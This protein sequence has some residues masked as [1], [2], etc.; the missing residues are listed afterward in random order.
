MLNT[1]TNGCSHPVRHTVVPSPSHCERILIAGAG[2]GFDL[3]SGLPI[4]FALHEH[5]ETIFLSN[6]T[7]TPIT[8]TDAR[9]VAAGVFE[10]DA[11]TDCPISY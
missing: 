3:L 1:S 9:P 8:R 4:A 10:V 11:D 5:L 2:G 6:L 7:F